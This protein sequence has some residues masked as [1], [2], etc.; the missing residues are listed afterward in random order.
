MQDDG[1]PGMWADVGLYARS[2][3]E[4]PALLFPST[5]EWDW[6]SWSEWEEEIRTKA[7]ELAD[8][9]PATRIGFRFAPEPRSLT[10]DLAIQAAGS[11]SVPVSGS[12][13]PEVGL[14]WSEDGLERATSS[15][16]S[17]GGPPRE[18]SPGVLVEEDGSPIVWGSEE[19]EA[20]AEA[21]GDLLVLD[22]PEL[23]GSRELAYLSGCPLE[24]WERAYLSWCLKRGVALVLAGD[25][26]LT[27]TGFLWSRPTV[28]CLGAGRLAQV[29][30]ALRSAGSLSSLRRRFRRLHTLLLHGT[31][32][33]S[34]I[35]RELWGRL[36]VRLVPAPRH[37]LAP[38]SPGSG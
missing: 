22:D 8:V 27:G 33:E 1:G 17:S 5:E 28:G 7:G 9:E 26:E 36:R 34:G 10:R 31:I 4:Q 29:E 18:E 37:L 3:P 16:A 30:V 14:W 24:P 38:E 23:G 13:A 32:D 20:A 21:V 12:P 11:V 15:G 35:D 6:I 25:R 19:L 2:M